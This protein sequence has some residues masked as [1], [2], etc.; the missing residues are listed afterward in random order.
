MVKRFSKSELPIVDWRY[1]LRNIIPVSFTKVWILILSYPHDYFRFEEIKETFDM[2]LLFE[3][4]EH[5]DW[6]RGREMVA[7]ILSDSESRRK[8]D[9]NHSQYLYSWPVLERCHSPHGLP[10]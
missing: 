9:P 4:I 10:L 8:G 7:G 2:V 6:K 5:L 1:E 3:V